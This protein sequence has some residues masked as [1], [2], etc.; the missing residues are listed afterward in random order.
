M[1]PDTTTSPATTNEDIITPYG[2]FLVK[3][4]NSVLVIFS[5]S[6]ESNYFI[7]LLPKI[8]EFY[9]FSRKI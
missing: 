2:M 3:N 4:N 9:N 5:S 1:I 6:Q 7:R 8:T